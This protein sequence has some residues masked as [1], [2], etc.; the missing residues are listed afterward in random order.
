MTA[1]FGCSASSAWASFVSSQN[2]LLRVTGVLGLDT[3]AS[4]LVKY[5]I[6]YLFVQAE[7][8]LCCP[9]SM[10]DSLARTLRKYGE[11]ALVEKYWPRM[12]QLRFEDQA[13]GAMFMTEQ[14]A[15]SDISYQ[16][17]MRSNPSYIDAHNRIMAASYAL[18]TD[19]A[20]VGDILTNYST[21]M[22]YD[23]SGD[24]DVPRSKCS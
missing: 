20:F 21:A 14:A 8:G 23:L 4:P 10:T 11:P 5:G 15:G 1:S 9:L 24:T 17:L 12:T 22:D 3:P 6:T 18:V 13:Q 19:A 16:L 7:F 2:H